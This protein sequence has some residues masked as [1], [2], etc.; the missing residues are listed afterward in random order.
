MDLLEGPPDVGSRG[1]LG[2]GG[3]EP[4]SGPAG[5]VDVLDPVALAANRG[6][7]GGGWDQERRHFHF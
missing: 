3:V 7:Q 2:L 1:C 5:V 6:W 4:D